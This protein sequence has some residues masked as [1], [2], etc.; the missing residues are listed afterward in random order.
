MKISEI[1]SLSLLAAFFLLLGLSFF[2]NY[3]SALYSD[4]SLFKVDLA[5]RRKDEKKVKKVT[6]LAP[7]PTLSRVTEENGALDDF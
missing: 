1:L 6:R 2:L 7:A 3:L 4:A 5:K